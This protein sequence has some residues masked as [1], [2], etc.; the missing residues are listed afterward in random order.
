MDHFMILLV[1]LDGFEFLLQFNDR[2]PIRVDAKRT[3]EEHLAV[4]GKNTACAVVK[5]WASVT[6]ALAN[7][8][9]SS[10]R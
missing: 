9:A 10:A 3:F 5:S 2:P 6:A 7:A 1:G 8:A 4:L